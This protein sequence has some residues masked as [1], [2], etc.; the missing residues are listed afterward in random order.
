MREA[1]NAQFIRVFAG[2]GSAQDV[3]D[4]ATKYGC[5]AVVL[6]P[7]DKAWANDP[8]AGNSAYR[9]AENRD[10]KWRIY[11]VVKAGKAAH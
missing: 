8:F 11:T 4:I 3:N 9:V 6:V 1:I 7:Q 2:E 5:D 10:G